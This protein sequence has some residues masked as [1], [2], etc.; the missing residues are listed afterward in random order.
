MLV[1][2]IEELADRS[3]RSLIGIAVVGDRPPGYTCRRM[4]SRAQ[5]LSYA[6][7]VLA[8]S[9]SVVFGAACST[10]RTVEPVLVDSGAAPLHVEV[11]PNCDAGQ[12]ATESGCVDEV[13]TDGDGENVNLHDLALDSACLQSW[14]R[15]QETAAARRSVTSRRG[16][17]LQLAIQVVDRECAARE[18]HLSVCGQAGWFDR[19]EQNRSLQ[20][21]YRDR[22]I[23]CRRLGII[24]RDMV[25]G[26][27]K[28]TQ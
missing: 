5:S 19:S 21:R 17:S 27:L 22:L 14:E 28:V 10:T 1:G 26:R 12:R 11:L 3:M 23:A 18:R 16:E 7:R 2:A 4:S 8:C 13:V 15:V 24:Y 6:V 9:T 20:V 25:A